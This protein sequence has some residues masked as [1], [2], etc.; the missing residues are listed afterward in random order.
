MSSDFL[1]TIRSDTPEIRNR[2]LDS[3]CRGLS[4]GDLLGACKKLDRF[5][6]TSDNLYEQ[7]RGAIPVER[8]LSI[9]LAAK[10]PVLRIWPDT[11]RRS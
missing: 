6:R 7:V 5:R 1:A 8:D 3:L 10:A 9:S 4:A 2:S 11:F